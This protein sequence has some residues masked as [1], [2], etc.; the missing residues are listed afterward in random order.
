MAEKHWNNFMTNFLGQ[1][2]PLVMVSCS[3]I[4]ETLYYY[5]GKTFMMPIAV[6]VRR[7]SWLL[8]HWDRGFESHPTHGCLSASFCILLSCVGRGLCVELITRPRSPVICRNKF[9][10]SE[11]FLNWNR[12]NPQMLKKKNFH[13]R[14]NKTSASNYFSPVHVST[15][16]C[17]I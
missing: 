14:N 15:N 9:I 2:V 10:I 12:N 1:Q 16:L 6:V 8:R 4:L 11:T 7:G 17:T 3:R 13:D 5:R